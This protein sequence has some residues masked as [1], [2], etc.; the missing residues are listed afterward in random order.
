MEQL[1]DLS[2]HKSRLKKRYAHK[3]YINCG[4]VKKD[5]NELKLN[6]KTFIGVDEVG[7][8]CLAGPVTATAVFVK[9][10]D[11]GM[12]SG[13]NDSKKISP[14]QRI[15]LYNKIK[16]NHLFSTVFVSNNLV[17]KLNIHKASLLAMR[18][19]VRKLTKKAE[20]ILVDGLFQIT[21][22]KAKQENYIKGDEKFY[23]ISAASIVA[24]V[25]RDRVMEKYNKKYP[26]F[27]FHK[28]KGYG[29][30]N[31]KNEIK[32]FGILEIHRKSFKLY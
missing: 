17:D 7:R 1:V 24:K 3:K 5:Y 20:V 6:Y 27:S 26:N 30:K 16:Q 4:K 18:L 15:L 21:E 11:I 9:K 2:L 31:H 13:I 29:T 10:E 23:T 8:G 25:E 22:I 12:I 28:H 19:A 14:K 32:E